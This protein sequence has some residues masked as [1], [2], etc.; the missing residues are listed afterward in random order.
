MDQENTCQ[1]DSS[2]SHAVLGGC[3]EW[4]PETSAISTGV[5]PRTVLFSGI[6][7]RQ[8]EGIDNRSVPVLAEC[9]VNEKKQST[10]IINYTGITTA[11]D[12]GPANGSGDQPHQIQKS[13]KN[14][15]KAVFDSHC[16]AAAAAQYYGT[17]GHG[18][19]VDLS[20]GESDYHFSWR[21][22][23]GKKYDWHTANYYCY[24]LGKGWQGVSIETPEEDKIISGII[25]KDKLEYIWTGGYRSG[26]D[27]YEGIAR[28][29]GFA[30]PSGYPFY[31]INW[32]YTGSEGLP[33]PDNAEE[34]KEF[35]LA[36]LNNFYN[37]GIKRHDVACYH[38]KA[39]ICERRAYKLYG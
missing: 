38:P 17:Y 9:K 6:R 10:R 15:M 32:S 35:C 31:G 16:G 13:M 12:P 18:G 29:P 5:N 11:A 34:G 39:N 14:E 27:H 1:E 30:W 25:Y 24:S 7:E 3:S 37:D 2:A 28:R 22:D 23:G 20:V 19:Q 36:V 8:T 26:Y 4:A 33:Q 21:H